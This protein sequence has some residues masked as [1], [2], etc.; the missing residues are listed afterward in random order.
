MKLLLGLEPAG[1]YAWAHGE[2]LPSEVQELLAKY[3]DAGRVGFFT[4][5]E[6]EVVKDYLQNAPTTA[7]VL[8]A[9]GYSQDL[10]CG[11]YG[12]VG[13]CLGDELQPQ[14]GFSFYTVAEQAMAFLLSQ[15]NSEDIKKQALRKLLKSSSFL[16]FDSVEHLVRSMLAGQ[17]VA[18][19]LLELST[20]R[21][22]QISS[23]FMGEFGPACHRVTAEGAAQG[24]TVRFGTAWT[25]FEVS[26]PCARDVHARG[27]K[28]E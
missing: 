2:V 25:G 14:E 3:K 17:A 28:S 27:W 6:P 4:C 12:P 21:H 11:K 15:P 1:A 23:S 18:G 5:G 24:G 8:S 20:G 16:S 26:P 7:T 22:K 19:Q 9:G 10:V 13:F